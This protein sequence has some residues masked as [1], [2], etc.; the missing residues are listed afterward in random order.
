M[1]RD[2]WDVKGKKTLQ[3]EIQ[4]IREKVDADAYEAIEAVRR[5]GNIGAHM[6]QDVNLI[7]DVEPAEAAQLLWLVEFLA[8]DWYG[9]RDERRRR[10]Q[11][12]TEL[13]SAKQEA[14]RGGPLEPQD[15][16]PSGTE[17]A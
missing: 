3:Q 4:A 15:S 13:D 14:R 7:V 9:R 16:P 8:A 11:E 2:F 6:E 12:L 5:L 1:I 17:G 10:M